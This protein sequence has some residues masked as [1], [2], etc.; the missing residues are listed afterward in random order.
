MGELVFNFYFFVNGTSN[1][2][3]IIYN[4]LIPRVKFKIV[5]TEVLKY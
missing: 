3:I 2:D 4:P 5:I 1:I